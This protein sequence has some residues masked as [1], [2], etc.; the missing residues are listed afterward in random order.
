[1]NKQQ[2]I[3]HIAAYY[4]PH[5]GGLERVAKMCAEGLAKRGY[6]VRAV[7]SSQG[8][9][10]SGTT[11]EGGLTVTT[12][13]SIEF[14]HIAIA[15]GFF[16]TMFTLPRNTILHLHLASA[17]FPEV[18]FVIAKLRRMKYVVHF[19]LDVG[20]SGVFGRLFLVYKSIVWGP[21][22]RNATHIVACANDQILIMEK[23]FNIP[24]EK[25]TV[26]P[27][28]VSEDFF[29]QHEYIPS[30][31]K[32]RL[33]YVGRLAHQKRVERIIEAMAKV[34]VPAEL[35]VV[36]DGED[37]EMLE[38][39]AKEH[40]LTNVFFVGKKND[41]EMQEYHRTHDALL[42][43]SD[44]EG[45][46]LVIL[47]AMAG[48]LP[49]VSTKVEGLEE[50]LQGVGVLVSEPYAENFAHEI[51]E[52]WNKPAKLIELSRMSKEKA[53]LYGWEKFIDSLLGVYQAYL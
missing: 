30:K 20:P 23:K 8:A 2:P 1:M 5:L 35:T 44:K 43:S 21:L 45:M 40:K 52:L 34:T 16:W 50:L 12:L 3:L 37:R 4:P 9:A 11:V 39:L 18:M 46:P 15:P 29:S 28:A 7:A 13:P 48:G 6:K 41:A 32:L 17:F 33:L 42:I 47:E 38:K 25:I 31:D 36:G 19:H 49:I 26:I 10:Q 22:L 53:K 51:D 14:A 27:N 24:K